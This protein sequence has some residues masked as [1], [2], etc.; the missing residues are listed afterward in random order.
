MAARTEGCD[1][2]IPHET[3]VYI[4]ENGKVSI[5]VWESGEIFRRTTRTYFAK[6]YYDLIRECDLL[7]R[8]IVEKTVPIE[9]VEP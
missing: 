5:E 8:R 7:I 6:D 4:G 9:E 3:R 1:T 2:M